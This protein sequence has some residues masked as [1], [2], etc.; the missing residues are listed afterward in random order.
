MNQPVCCASYR[1]GPEDENVD[2][3]TIWPTCRPSSLPSPPPPPPRGPEEEEGRERTCETYLV[4]GQSSAGRGVRAKNERHK[5]RRICQQPRV[6]HFIRS[7]AKTN[8]LPTSLFWICT[9]FLKVAQLSLFLTAAEHNTYAIEEMPS[10]CVWHL[11]PLRMS[12]LLLLGR[13][14]WIRVQTSYREHSEEGIPSVSST[15]HMHVLLSNNQAR[16]G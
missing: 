2:D 10:F 14:N 15:L 11:A 4:P 3:D 6:G 5:L 7:F 1:R 12:G 16:S 13:L 9:F 8:C